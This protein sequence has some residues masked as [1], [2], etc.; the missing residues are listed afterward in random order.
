MFVDVHFHS[1]EEATVSEWLKKQLSLGHE[2]I[3][4]AGVKHKEDLPC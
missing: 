4:R 1:E 3:H 2:F